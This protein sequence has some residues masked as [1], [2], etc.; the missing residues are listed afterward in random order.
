MLSATAK[1]SGIINTRNEAANIRYS[2]ASLVSWCDEVIVMDQESDDGTAEIARA[3]G[4]TV[5]S[6]PHTGFV[7]PARAAAVD[8]ATGDWLMILDADE[9]VPPALG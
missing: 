5:L 3:A 8:S 6:H 9:I 1:I 7:E 2:V 4:A